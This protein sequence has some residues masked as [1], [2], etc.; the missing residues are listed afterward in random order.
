MA[1]KLS[2]TKSGAKQFLSIGGSIK[3]LTY[4]RYLN[5]TTHLYFQCKCHI[6]IENNNYNSQ[7]IKKCIVIHYLIRNS[8][9]KAIIQGTIMHRPYSTYLC[10][11]STYLLTLACIYLLMYVRKCAPLG[12]VT[13]RAGLH[14]TLL[15]HLLQ[16][17]HVT[18]GVR[19][20]I[21]SWNEYKLCF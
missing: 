10:I 3:L 8:S 16:N 4:A 19:V 15:P 9:S 12:K 11:I 5:I 2:L 6:T 18:Y 21:L 20:I 17:K 1:K 14:E 7:M 13:P